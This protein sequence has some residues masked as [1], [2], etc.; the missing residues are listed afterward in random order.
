MD[1][2][3]INITKEKECEILWSFV[4]PVSDN[5][6]SLE[7]LL[8]ETHE[9]VNKNCW[10]LMEAHDDYKP[11]WF[12]ISRMLLCIFEEFMEHIKNYCLAYTCLLQALK[13]VLDVEGFEEVE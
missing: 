5:V 10:Y 3:T 2:K 1:D 7:T 4:K 9:I 6:T 8:A 13:D 12:G 11:D